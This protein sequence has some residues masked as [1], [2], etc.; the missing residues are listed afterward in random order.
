MKKT[1]YLI[2]LFA[3]AAAFAPTANA[4]IGGAPA[5]NNEAFPPPVRTPIPGGIDVL[6]PPGAAPGLGPL[7]GLDGA[8]PVPGAPYSDSPYSNSP[9]GTPP[10]SPYA[11][12]PGGDVIVG[13]APF[14]P[15]MC[16]Y[17]QPFGRFYVAADA[18][19]WDRTEPFRRQIA[20][21]SADATPRLRTSDPNFTHEVFPR[22]TFGY[23]A[24]N[25]WAIEG[26]IYYKDDFD[27][28]ANYGET[29]M[30]TA[31]FFGVQPDASDWTGA[32]QINLR[33]ATGLHSYEISAINTIAGI[34]PILGI[35]YMEF[36]DRATFTAF[37]NANR[38]DASIGT[39]NMLLGPQAG[40]KVAYDGGLWGIEGIGKVGWYYN[41]AHITTTIQ[42]ANN[43][44]T[45]RSVRRNGQND[46]CVFE[47]GISTY[48][49]PLTWL[50]ARLGYQTLGIVNTAMAVD[51]IS[52]ENTAAG[53]TTGIIPNA[54]GDIIF[55]G[56]FLGLEGRW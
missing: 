7:P 24:P 32:D 16:N 48:Y 45:Y 30:V 35:R 43:T 9:Y 36:R 33:M 28:I 21:R 1:V 15:S 56:F 14:D 12:S 38:S 6:A 4:Q 10:A 54:H 23:V 20:V 27:A 31:N 49:R 34:Q 42:D 37:D 53:N 55:H 50:T 29:D 52:D 46:A 17:Q 40:A 11:V 41:D 39:Y 22:M 19:Y 8:P 47:L 2:C 13:Q 5:F 44:T 3:A 51:Q 26:T 25:N 18:M